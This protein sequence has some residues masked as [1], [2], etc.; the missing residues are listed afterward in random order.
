MCNTTSSPS[1]GRACQCPGSAPLA[2]AEP[3]SLFGSVSELLKWLADRT[4]PLAAVVL[5][6]AAFFWHDFRREFKL[7]VS[8]AS[9]SMLSALPALFAVV[10]GAA[11]V[12]LAYVLLPSL[13]LGTPIHAEGP[14][15]VGLMQ[16]PARV[17]DTPSG[18]TVPTAA[19]KTLFK[20]WMGMAL[21]LVLL[22]G[23][24][25]WWSV[26]NDDEPVWYGMAVLFAAVLAQWLNAWRIVLREVKAKAHAAGIQEPTWRKTVGFGAL[27]LMSLLFQM[28]VGFF[29]LNTVLHATTGTEA[30]DIVFAILY[31]GTAMGCIAIAQMVVAHR[32]ARGWY[33]NVLKHGVCLTLGALAAV[34]IIQPVGARL[35]SIAL[36]S[37]ATPMD[38]CTVFVV[39]EAQKD[40]ALAALLAP[41]KIDETTDVEF[42]FLSDNQYYVRRKIHDATVMFDAKAVVATRPCAKH[43][44]ATEAPAANAQPSE[45]AQTTPAKSSSAPARF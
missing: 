14:T 1:D 36:V 8:F 26:A 34:A 24:V 25:I 4:A 33:P 21:A 22:W 20:T 35:T 41:G 13:I 42:V 2:S 9:G 15:M 38:L 27:L 19:E 37:S 31:V 5:G 45:A 29:V 30:K 16:R 17:P 40:P 12:L 43:A 18:P 23:G 10:C 6:I 11:I 39:R 7:P 32:V 28:F 44:S 3:E